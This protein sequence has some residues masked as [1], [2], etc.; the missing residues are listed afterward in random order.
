LLTQVQP[1]YPETL[2]QLHIGGTVRLQITISAQGRVESVT[3]LG[4]NPILGESAIKA[5]QLWIF[6]AA[7]SRTTQ[8]VTLPFDSP[9]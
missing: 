8:I 7:P 9:R 5:V 2:R 3:L 1:E 4:G 6:A